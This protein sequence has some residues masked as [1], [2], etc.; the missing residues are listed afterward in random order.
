MDRCHR[1]AGRCSG[2]DRGLML[3]F[4]LSVQAVLARD[5]PD[6][7]PR[8]DDADRHRS[9]ERPEAEIFHIAY[10]LKGANP[11]RPGQ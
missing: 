11:Q 9:P 3:Y 5:L 6:Y 2:P 1:T 4:G 7:R 10:T 8:R